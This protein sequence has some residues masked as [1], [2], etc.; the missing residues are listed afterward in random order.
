MQLL[1]P[2]IRA[3]INDLVQAALKRLPFNFDPSNPQF[4]EWLE[5]LIRY[6]ARHPL[7]PAL[8]K[9]PVLGGIGIADKHVR[10]APEVCGEFISGF[11]DFDNPGTYG[12]DGYFSRVSLLV[13]G[14]RTGWQN[15]P[16]LLRSFPSTELDPGC[17]PETPLPGSFITQRS[18]TYSGLMR[19]VI[20]LQQGSTETIKYRS[21]SG[22][23]HGIYVGG[24]GDHYVIEISTEDGITAWPI[25]W[26][27]LLTPERQAELHVDLPYLPSMHNQLPAMGDRIILAPAD[28]LVGYAATFPFSNMLGGWRFSY[29]GHEAQTVTWYQPDTWKR[30]R[31]T[32]ITITESGG[33]P[34]SA[35][36]SV[37]EETYLSGD[38]EAGPKFPQY[39]PEALGGGVSLLTF[40]LRYGEAPP[41][42]LETRLPIDVYYIDGET[43]PVIV[44]ID[45]V[46][47]PPDEELNTS[48]DIVVCDGTWG[49]ERSPGASSGVFGSESRTYS[50]RRKYSMD[51]PV[52]APD[53]PSADKP[54]FTGTGN[55]NEIWSE[56]VWGW[57]HVR[58]NRVFTEHWDCTQL[59]GTG[60][61][62][63]TVH[64]V[65]IK[66]FYDAE[67]SIFYYK[68]QEKTEYPNPGRRIN[69]L[70]FGDKYVDC[71]FA[72]PSSGCVPTG[73][74]ARFWGRT[75]TTQS[76][77]PVPQ[78][79]YTAFGGVVD[80]LEDPFYC[81]PWWLN[82]SQCPP[83]GV[84]TWFWLYTGETGKSY[85]PSSSTY[86][87]ATEREQTGRQ[88]L[89][90]LDPST[91]EMVQVREID[92][93]ETLDPYT[94]INLALEAEHQY[95]GHH[96]DVFSG[97]GMISDRMNGNKWGEYYTFK[98]AENY[99]DLEG[100]ALSGIDRVFF[101]VPLP[102]E[103]E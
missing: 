47:A 85:C 1:T 73:K 24:G 101:G 87:G 55:L 61:H 34:V 103:H 75:C 84:E 68:E 42:G 11:A 3:R 8:E 45:G 88:G 79:E 86:P 81:I 13:N 82:S 77:G 90:A 48:P 37:E 10:W 16:A 53:D 5:S 12:E 96:G 35:S 67:G 80:F 28:D 76:S 19:Q 59:Q 74:I 18:T 30:S 78:T 71:R 39:I 102:E 64:E 70:A 38:N 43:D 4:L 44:Y 23:S 27:E 26:C 15:S 63:Q 50:G 54:R 91:R 72:D 31:R 66:P 49:Y 22:I 14:V 95:M 60:T 97:G 62:T 57:C 94:Q 41:P 100:L 29:D 51:G 40:D 58:N 98:D 7:D 36:V 33:A 92:S 52:D 20:Q 32:K 21:C 99:Y 56:Q 93:Y 25:A 17:S 89:W 9:P 6:H 65:Y 2:T 83:D 46:T 69:G